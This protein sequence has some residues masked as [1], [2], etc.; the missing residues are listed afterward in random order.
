MTKSKPL[1]AKL[2]PGSRELTITEEGIKQI[3]KLTGDGVSLINIAAYL[4]MNAR[5]L[6]DIRKR[7][8]EVD[9]AISRGLAK[10]EHLVVSALRRRALDD[11][12]K[13][14]TTAAIFLLKARHGYEIGR[15]K[16]PEHLTIVNNDNRSQTIQLPSPLQS[17]EYYERI[18]ELIPD[19][20]SE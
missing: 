18:K 8:P 13:D 4:S 16:V 19:D 15:Q 1:T 7:Q 20:P 5:T 10:E 17:K 12:R 2:T 11:S 14:C 9:E 6:R 3:E